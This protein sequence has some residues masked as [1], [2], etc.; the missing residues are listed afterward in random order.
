M[1]RREFITGTAATAAV[2][3]AQPTNAQSTGSKRL[4]ILHPVR[5]PEQLTQNGGFRPY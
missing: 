4:A 2:G 5:P 3:L 1:R